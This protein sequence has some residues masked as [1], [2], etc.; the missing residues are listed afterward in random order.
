METIH[1]EGIEMSSPL[2]SVVIPAYNHERFVGEAVE[3]VLRQSCDDLELIVVDDGSTDSTA[4]IVQGYQDNRLH[5]YFQENQDAYNTINRGIGLAAGEYISIL[6]SDDVYELT[7][8]ENLLKVLERNDCVCTFSDVIPISDDGLHYTAPE[9]GWNQWHKKNRDFYFSCGDLYT[10]FL[11][12][13]FMVTTSNLFMTSAAAKKVGPFCSLRYL[14]DYDFIFRMMKTFPGQ[15]YYADTLQLL[16]YRIHSGNTLSEAAIIGREQDQEL[17]RKYLL[18][19]I[20][21]SLHAY[22]EA[23]SDRLVELEQELCRVRM[24]LHPVKEGGVRPA[25]KNLQHEVKNWLAKMVLRRQ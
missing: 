20:P 25:L 15:V 24:Q 11:K 10:A 8:L 14:H 2:I 17:I 18:A 9:F 21:D 13:N 6:N 19:V 3:S 12:G 1:R 22:V 23:G 16:R 7:R 5:Y 4:E